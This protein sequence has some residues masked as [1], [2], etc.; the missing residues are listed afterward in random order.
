MSVEEVRRAALAARDALGPAVRQRK[1]DAIWKRLI[2][3][4]AFQTASMALFYLS[5]GS[6]VDTE[7]MRRMTRELGMQVACPRSRPGDRSMVF[8]RL[9]PDEELSPGPYGIL[10]PAS[11]AP[12]AV[13]G[14]Q[15]VVL[16][17]GVLFDR[18]GDRLGFGGGYYDRWLAGPGRGLAT[19][20]LA[21]QEQLVD[22]VQV[23]A[24]DRPVDHLLTDMESVDCV[25]WRSA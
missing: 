10:Q 15:C 12:E 18:W 24:H 21:F 25:A 1:S 13:L 14:P 6:E 2:E 11:D 19:V 17:P 5:F 22:R 4:P 20:G 16:V 7:M 23:R 8:H 3:L 9:G